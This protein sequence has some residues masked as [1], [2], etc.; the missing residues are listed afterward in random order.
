MYIIDETYFTNDLSIPNLNEMDSDNLTILERYI[1]KYARELMQLVL[2]YELYK[3]FDANKLT[4]QKWIDLINGKEYTKDGKLY[5]W[6]GLKYTDGIYKHSILAKYVFF[7]WYRENV[8]ITTQTGEKIV[9][10]QNSIS[11]NSNQKLVSVWNSFINEYQNRTTFAPKVYQSRNNVI[12]DWFG[13]DNQFVTLTEFILDNETDYLEPNLK[14][15]S[16]D[17]SFGL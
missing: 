13:S 17:N 7:N 3:D 10:A 16:H 8:T 12:V 11:V 4:A 6:K 2:G 15:F 5:K 9:N 1:D 14:Y